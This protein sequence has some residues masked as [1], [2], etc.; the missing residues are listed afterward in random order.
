M[1]MQ[2]ERQQAADWFR[3]LRDRIVAAFEGL[4]DRGPGDAAPG[5]FEVRPTARGADG[6]GGL[7]SVMRGGRVFE[8]VGVNVSTVG[9]AFDGE[10][11]RY[12]D[13]LENGLE[14]D[15]HTDGEY[16]VLS[17]DALWN[18]FHEQQQLAWQRL[19]CLKRARRDRELLRELAAGRGLLLTLPLLGRDLAAALTA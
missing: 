6:G 9:G 13:A 15:L 5:R 7:M 10:F 2:D 14:L 16:S 1:E 12:H 3:A 17:E 11:G 18:A 4:E 8:K 19:R